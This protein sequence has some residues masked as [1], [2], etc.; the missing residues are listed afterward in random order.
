M[1]KTKQYYEQL[2][3]EQGVDISNPEEFVPA[4]EQLMLDMEAEAD[5]EIEAEA[6]SVNLYEKYMKQLDEQFTKFSINNAYI[7]LVGE[8]AELYS[9]PTQNA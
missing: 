7:K 3:I 2:L 9:T 4:F 1:S 8:L 5:A 6:Q